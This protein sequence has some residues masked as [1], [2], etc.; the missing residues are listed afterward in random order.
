MSIE[1]ELES[2]LKDAMRSGDKA[3]R[4]VIRQV[5]SEVGVART[6]P[7]FS[8]E[9]GDELYR[10]VIEGYVKKVSKSLDEYRGLGDQGADMARKLE[11]E[12]D[13]LSRWLPTKLGEA[14][15]RGLVDEA[16]RELG[17]EG[18][19]KA[20]GR[21]IGH[22]MKSHKDEVDGGL[23]NRLVRDALGA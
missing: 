20:S 18:D 14:E 9:T 10:S 4:D 7:G 17:V 12:I 19:P 22:V 2:D 3:R 5:R 15:T 21:V 1:S 11:Y 16:I 13:Y 23:V 8:G 6:A